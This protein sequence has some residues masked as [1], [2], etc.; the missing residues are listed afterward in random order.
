MGRPSHVG[1]RET[2][3]NPGSQA[4]N[5]KKLWQPCQSLRWCDYLLLL[6]CNDNS[7]RDEPFF[8]GQSVA[9]RPPAPQSC[10][11]VFADFGTELK[12]GE[13]F[14][15]RAETSAF[16]PNIVSV[17][18]ERSWRGFGASPFL[19]ATLKHQRSA[20]FPRHDPL[21]AES[22]RLGCECCIHCALRQG[23]LPP[24]F[25]QGHDARAAKVGKFS[26]PIANPPQLGSHRTL[27]FNQRRII[28]ISLRAI[29]P[30]RYWPV[31]QVTEPFSR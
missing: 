24:A 20:E 5:R 25:L 16:T 26:V 17:L 27:W 14:Y 13:S 29:D 10:L 30:L 11:A 22:N 23:R 31:L 18:G 28:R 1:E 8:A 4:A 7:R 3:Q 6:C 9:L 12:S 21:A 15:Q 19:A 2:N